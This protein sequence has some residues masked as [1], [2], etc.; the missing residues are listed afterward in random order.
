[1]LQT[2]RIWVNA[3]LTLGLLL[4][5]GLGVVFAQTAT[6][7][8][9]LTD[10]QNGA[11]LPNANVVVSGAGAVTGAIANLDG[12]YEV[13][14]LVAGIYTVSVSLVGYEKK[15]VE[16]VELKPGE[17]REINVA[18]NSS[19]IRLNPVVTSASRRQEK[20]LEAPAAISVLE[21]EQIQ[22]RPAM[23]VIDHLRSLPGVDIA[24]GGLVQ[25]NVVVRGFNTVF[26]TALLVLTDNRYAN[27]PSLRVNSYSLLPLANEDISRIE[28]V[29]GPGAA[30]Y[31]PNS[32]NGVLHLIS[33][34]SF[35]SEGTTISVGGGGR[36]FLNVSQRAPSGGHNIYTAAVRHAGHLSETVGY[37]ISAQ[38]YQGRDWQSYAAEDA[39]PRKIIF[40][41]QTSTGRV[42]QGDSLINRPDFNVEKIGGEARLDF[43]L[44]N[45]A[46]LIF[47][48]G[49][50]QVDQLELTGLGAYAAK[51][52]FYSFAQARFNYKNLFVQGF[53]NASN[54]GDTYSLRTGDYIKDSS[55]LIV[56]Q[57]QHS[58]ALGGWQ[59]FTYG[60]DVL[61][62]RPDTKNTIHGRN[63]K[64]DN[65]N[66]LGV[67]VQSETKVFPKIDLVTAARFDDHNQLEAEFSP[68]AALIFKPAAEHNFRLTYNRAFR[69][70]TTVEL[71]ADIL[72]E[73]VPNPFDPTKPLL[74]VRALG[75]PTKTGYTF[76][77]DS[78]GR[79]QMMSQLLP[80][81]GYVPAT[82][83]TVWP[84]IRQ[85]ALQ[86]APVE[87]QALLN[88]TLPQQLG[89]TVQGDLRKLNPG[90]RGFDLV[91]NLPD[92]PPLKSEI[93]N[94]FEFGY[95]GVVGG[96]L[97]VGLDVYHTRYKD[98]ISDFQV[99]NPNVFANPEQLAA[100]LQPSGAVMANAL[101]AQGLPAEQAQALA[102]QIVTVLVTNIAAL[103]L[104]VISPEQVAN[105]TDVLIANR[106]FGKISVNGLDLNLIYYANPSWTFSGN[107]SFVTKQGF[108]LFARRNRVYFRNVDGVDDIAL[109]APGNKAGMA[110][111]YHFRQ[112]LNTELRSRYVEG[113]P[114][115]AGVYIGDVQTYTIFD[116]NLAYNLPFTK[117][118]RVTLS[119]LNLFDKKHREF[120]GAPILGRLVLARLTQTF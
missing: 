94:T 107:Y 9:K 81:A 93:N 51:N 26:S 23:T 16:P 68:R 38:Y 80:G 74:S 24:T 11:P 98:F 64:K 95:K 20:A 111:Q 103:P 79:P 104:G 7:R 27:V 21:T 15:I 73:D 62:T 67:Y 114:M 13:K 101:I 10:A 32:A 4:G 14:N 71:F 31:G 57:A 8:G 113:F 91:T 53:V 35:E 90:T 116:V 29:S 36:D 69:T 70:P 28:V 102:A 78:D 118:T 66:E 56:G 110:V 105:D 25:S 55:K 63:E 52:W 82:V 59:R 77:R 85:I 18:L 96:K 65:V 115:K 43:R 46:A 120:I 60:L 45:D 109:N 87:L 83:N 19:E 34:S 106:N 1:M 75:I 117:N 5:L 61:L 97:L 100:A 84:A 108:N 92:Q 58:L 30:L 6:L 41:Y 47:N 54:A 39:A 112:G 37:K 89:T 2:R 76:H 40:G 22:R 72:S 44:R 50:N 3:G 99:V 33:R 12:Q 17:A 86:Q 48:A 119:G 49:I 88:A 42:T